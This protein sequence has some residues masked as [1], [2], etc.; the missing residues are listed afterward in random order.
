MSV[1]LPARLPAGDS[2]SFALCPALPAGALW[3]VTFRMAG[4]AG[5]AVQVQATSGAGGRWY[6]KVPAATTAGFLPGRW[7]W[8]VVAAAGGDRRTLA[9]GAVRVLPDPMTAAGG[10]GFW[11]KL[12]DACRAALLGKA[13]TDQMAVKYAGRELQRYSIKELRELMAEAERQLSAGGDEEVRR[14]RRL[15]RVVTSFGGGR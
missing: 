15:H 3:V 1:K 9:Q 13:S 8:A 14:G 2:L 5:G 11:E 7:V 6:V 10:A 4:P 12:R